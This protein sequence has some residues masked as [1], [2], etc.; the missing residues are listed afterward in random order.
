[1]NQL[2]VWAKSLT[3]WFKF[4]WTCSRAFALP[5]TVMAWLTAFTYCFDGD[6]LNGIIALIGIVFAH[7][8][9]NLFD[10]YND[11]KILS[12]EEEYLNSAQ[13][14]KCKMIKDGCIKHKDL[15]NAGLICCEIVRGYSF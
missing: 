10:D 1:M 13:I 9:T 2:L 14:C 15:L 6:K 8:A 12:Q 3:D 4:W 5:V 7:L 11:Y